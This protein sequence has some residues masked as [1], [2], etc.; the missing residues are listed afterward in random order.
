MLAL[1]PRPYAIALLFTSLVAIACGG[2]PQTDGSGAAGEAALA[3]A[4]AGECLDCS[5]SNADLAGV[6]LATAVLNRS[7]LSGANLQG[8]TLSSALLDQANLSNADLS[9]AD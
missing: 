9:G 2:P 4:Q 7:D 6:D 3:A 1:F 5:L 8:S